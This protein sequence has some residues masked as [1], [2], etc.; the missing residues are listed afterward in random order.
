MRQ[1]RRV[2]AQAGFIVIIGKFIDGRTYPV[3]HMLNLAIVW[4]GRLSQ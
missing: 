1:G 2:L 4:Q 3:W